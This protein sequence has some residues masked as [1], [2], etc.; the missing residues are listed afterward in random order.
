VSNSSF[1]DSRA[2]DGFRKIVGQE[3]NDVWIIDLKGNAR[4][5]GERRRQEG[6][7][8]FSDQIRVGVAVY[9]FVKTERTKGCKI[10][11]EVVR[12]YASAEEKISFL[13]SKRIGERKF[14]EVRPDTRN[15]WINQG[16]EDFYEL[17]PVADRETK[18]VSI[19][20]QDQAIFKTYS[21]GVKTQ[22]DEWMYDF[23]PAE[24]ERKVKYF[25]GVYESARKTKAGAT[26][27]DVKWDRELDRYLK[28]GI[29]LSFRKQSIVRANYRP[30]VSM[31]LYFDRHLNGMVYLMPSVFP[32]GTT[33]NPCI[34]V[35]GDSTGKPYFSFAIDR[36]PDLNFVSPASGGTRCLPRSRFGDDGSSIDNIT[37]WATWSV[38]RVLRRGGRQRT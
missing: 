8:I 11:Y 9:F 25:I 36:I 15:R 33:K 34:T 7:N 26:S 5:S 24:L 29:A 1:V 27:G 18:A 21:D 16:R 17:M 6:G 14:D 37:D 4:T 13:T 20:N 28:K 12:D 22:R 19:S 35:M 10:H 31:S 2:F 32:Q 3:F 23:D 38:P 30:F